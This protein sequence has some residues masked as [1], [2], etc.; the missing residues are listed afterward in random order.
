MK[1]LIKTLKNASLAGVVYA[2][3]IDISPPEGWGNL[4]EIT[5]PDIISTVIKLILIVAALIAF[6]FLVI[7]GIKWI[8][9]GGD[10]EATAAAQKTITAA[11]VGLIIVFSAW[12]IIK[13][14]E[15]FFGFQI[16]SQ[17]KI[18]EILPTTP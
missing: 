4:A 7:G 11:L 15:T 3:Q 13:L 5:L 16:L 8:V 17:L 9:S 10:K 12:A 1:S 18:P 2:Q 6:I 14:L